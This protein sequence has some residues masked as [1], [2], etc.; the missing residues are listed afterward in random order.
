MQRYTAFQYGGRIAFDED[1]R[2]MIERTR[3]PFSKIQR[4][5]RVEDA[6]KGPD[7]THTLRAPQTS[8][9]IAAPSGIIS[10]AVGSYLPYTED[11]VSTVKD[12][13]RMRIFPPLPLLS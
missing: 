4:C 2:C 13:A 3:D 5:V 10:R 11:E 7:V 9:G 12:V 8:R 1:A 6:K